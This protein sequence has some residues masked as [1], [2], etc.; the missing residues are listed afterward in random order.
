[1]RRRALDEVG[2]Q[3]HPFPFGGGEASRLLP[4]PVRNAHP[5]EIVDQRRAPHE[6]D[7]AGGQAELFRRR[8]RELRDA[9]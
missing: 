7:V 5:T 9:A 3:A 8:G 1:M 6:L 4:D 2:M